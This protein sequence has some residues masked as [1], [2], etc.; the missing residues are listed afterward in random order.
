[1]ESVKTPYE[2]DEFFAS[3]MEDTLS[4]F[5]K[6]SSR[7]FSHNLSLKSSLLAAFL[8]ILSFAFYFYNLNISHFFLVGVYFLA[9]TPALIDSILDLKEF[10]VNIDVLMTLAALLSVVIGSEIEGGLLLVLFS[11]SGSIEESVTSKTKNALHQLHKL[12]PTLAYVK[13]DDGHFIQKSIKTI[14]KGSTILVK[15]GEIIPLDGKVLEGLS[16]VNL[17]HLT[18]ESTPVT[19]KTG[20]E[21]QAGSSNLD[22]YLTIEVLKT[23]QESTL[24]KIIELIS[25]AQEAKPNVQ[26]FLDRF[27]KSYASTIISLSFLF[28]LCLPKLIDMP[29]LGFEGSIYRSLA[30]LIAASPCALIIATPT[31]YLSAISAC[32]KKG[33]LL[34]GGVTLDAFAKCKK[35][36][37]DKTGTL[38]TGKLKF[39][40]VLSLGQSQV[41]DDNLIQM[42]ASLEQAVKH[43]IADAILEESKKRGLAPLTFSQVKTFAGLGVE[44]TFNNQ[45]VRVGRPSWIL[46]FFK[47]SAPNIPHE[48]GKMIALMQLGE[49]LIVFY[50]ED[51]IRPSIAAVI[52][53]LKNKLSLKVMMLTGDHK[54]SALFVAKEVG[55]EEV[56]AELKPEDKLSLISQFSSEHA[57]AMIGDGINDAPSLARAHV[58]ISMGDVGS[59][60][61][62]EA[63]DVVFL[64]D[65]LTLLPFLYKKSTKTL[66]IVKEN[67]TLAI[68]VIAFVSVFALFGIV[69]LWLAVILHEGGTIVVGLNSLRLLK[70]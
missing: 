29:Y 60:T 57:I 5:L 70:K 12:S 66:A 16:S 61:A 7:K 56:Y 10:D 54:E 68:G 35:I 53:E 32:A 20:D 1:M 65:D 48:S 2:F 9:G 14:L 44:G 67:L 47:N 17:V 45:I 46:S 3:K 22:G 30:F 19:K 33:I 6:P 11:L 40:K 27:G 62:I 43:P 28:A 18:G 63:S 8:L 4:P 39:Q 42:A 21:V 59:Q 55:I 41:S 51:Q 49:Q 15:S 26:K 69:P 23:A 24:S 64:K 58:G 38:T 50:F 13:T 34:K 37:F 36:A 25:S 31:A 52:D